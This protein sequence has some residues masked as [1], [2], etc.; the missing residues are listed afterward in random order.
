MSREIHKK[1]YSE[2]FQMVL[3]GS[4]TFDCR[5]ADFDCE[6]GDILVLDEIDE[7]RNFTGRSV[8]RKVGAVGYTKEF[9]KWHAPEDVEKYGFQVISLLEEE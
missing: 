7:K 5:L 8:R 6:P 4:K 1:A 2:Y 3:D 9:A